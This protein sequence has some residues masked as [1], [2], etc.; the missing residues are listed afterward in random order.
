MVKA[1]LGCFIPES[2]MPPV[3]LVHLAMGPRSPKH[4]GDDLTKSAETLQSFKPILNQSTSS[5]LSTTLDLDLL[6]SPSVPCIT[7][8]FLW[9]Q[10]CSLHL[11]WHQSWCPTYPPLLQAFLCHSVLLVRCNADSGSL[12]LNFSFKSLL[13]SSFW[14]CLQLVAH[15][16]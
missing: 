13:L 4:T 11:H 3:S 10:V 9:I 1:R 7:A 2:Y 15:W 6:L 16:S 5:P 14:W 8:H 12:N